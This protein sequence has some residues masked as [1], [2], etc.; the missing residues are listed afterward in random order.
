MLTLEG[1]PDYQRVRLPSLG[2]GYI[3]FNQCTQPFDKVEVRQ[4]FAYGVNWQG[5]VDTFYGGLADRAGG[6]SPPAILG[7]N[8]DLKPIPYDPD[9]AKEL[10]TAAGVPDGFSTDFWYIPVIRGYFPDSKAIAEAMSADLAKIGIKL[11]LKTKD[12]G[13]YLDDRKEGKFPVWMLGWGS[14]NGD[15]DNFIGYHFIYIDGK[16]PNKED[17]YENQKLQDLLNAGPRRER[18]RQARGDLQGSR[19]DRLRRYGAR[20][21]GVAEGRQFLAQDHQE[22]RDL[23]VPRPLRVHVLRAVIDNLR[24]VMQGR[25]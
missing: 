17:C 15:P 20:P 12:W 13:P 23:A 2:V 25:V 11:N 9:K 22:R 14:D 4:A 16:T 10:L 5:I 7:S 19:A 18:Y 8:P 3:N 6:F 1:N 21:G 24:R